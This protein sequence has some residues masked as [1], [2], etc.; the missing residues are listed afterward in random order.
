MYFFVVWSE[1]IR[2]DTRTSDHDVLEHSVS[3][4]HFTQDDLS[5]NEAYMTRLF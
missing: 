1:A 5:K 2:S 4:D 3:I